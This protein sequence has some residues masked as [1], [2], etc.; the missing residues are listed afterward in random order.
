MLFA[1]CCVL[2]P[3]RT[4][5]RPPHRSHTGRRAALAHWPI[6]PL[7]RLWKP[8]KR[9][10]LIEWQFLDKLSICRR[11][12][13]R[14]ERGAR[15]ARAKVAPPEL[16]PGRQS[17]ARGGPSLAWLAPAGQAVGR[18]LGMF[19]CTVRAHLNAR[20]PLPPGQ[21]GFARGANKWRRPNLVDI[22]HVAFR[23]A[24]LHTK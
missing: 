4:V 8:H 24:P 5:G 14:Q 9:R 2:H 3:L 6:G 21:P 16:R 13:L 23:A 11:P 15:A 19:E 22:P 1:V 12:A 10:L 18:W 17:S 20:W 7:A